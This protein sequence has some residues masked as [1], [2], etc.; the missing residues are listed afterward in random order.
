MRSLRGRHNVFAVILI[1][2]MSSN[3]GC[4]GSGPT[5]QADGGSASVDVST[6][7]LFLTNRAQAI[8]AEL[9]RC[10]DTAEIDSFFSEFGAHV[11]NPSDCE[12]AIT[13]ILGTLEPDWE[14]LVASGE[15]T[16]D[17]AAAEA[18][19]AGFSNRE[20]GVDTEEL[21]AVC[22]DVFLPNQEPGQ[23]C[24]DDASCK[25]TP[26]GDYSR[27]EIDT[28]AASG[29]CV[30]PPGIDEPCTFGGC[31]SGLYCVPDDG[32]NP[33][34]CQPKIGEAHPCRFGRD[35]CADG[36]HCQDDGSGNGSCQPLPVAGQPCQWEC[37]TGFICQDD[38]HGNNVCRAPAIA[39]EGEPCDG[40][41][42]VCA[43]GLF[44]TPLATSG[45]QCKAPQPNGAVCDSGEQCQSG[46]CP[47]EPGKGSGTCQPAECDG[48]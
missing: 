17:R 4:S 41:T 31:A 5:N 22:D 46:Y 45:Y 6:P 34:T 18:C 19:I 21:P 1:G 25:D 20:C 48:Q 13:S 36:L 8:C 23:A 33:T 47:W 11:Q 10:C 26:A 9:F 38:G 29:V 44:C 15:V 30:A 27:C 7:G 40:W 16:Y 35:Q 42:I 43:T 28:G 37:A 14:A 39:N 3:T 24:S 12:T 2:F 32:G